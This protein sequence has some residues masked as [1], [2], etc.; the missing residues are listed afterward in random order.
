[1][2]KELSIKILDE[3]LFQLGLNHRQLAKIIGVD[4]Q[5][6]YQISH[7]SRKN[8]LSTQMAERINSEFPFINLDYLLTGEGDILSDIENGGLESRKLKI[9]ENASKALLNNSENN[10]E[11][12]E[13]FKGLNESYKL[14]MESMDRITR[15]FETLVNK[16]NDNKETAQSHD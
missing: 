7:S 15:S 9:L 2:N 12:I 6:L 4:P 16:F 14:G 3:V 5:S 10:K 1:M 13:L 8:C 11:L